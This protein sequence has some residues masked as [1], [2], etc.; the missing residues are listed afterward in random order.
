MK[1]L[2]VFDH[3]YTA[4]ACNNEPHK[5]S[6][7]AAICKRLTGLM[8]ERGE[9]V[10]VIDL[11]ADHFNPVMS[12]EELALWRRGIALN[13]QVADY[14]K[15]IQQADRI[16]FIFPIWWELMPAMTKGF[17]DK[18]YAKD[19]LYSQPKQ[20]PMKTKLNPHKKIMVFTVMGTPKLLYKLVF[21]KPVIKALHRGT[22]MKTGLKHFEWK[23]FSHVD[24]LTL[25]EREKLL[26]NISL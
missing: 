20:G 16:I 15:R 3:P 21:G 8:L 24:T 11:H 17:L 2:I 19:I 22:F 7:C 25:E 18:V 9:E 14:Q 26:Q 4:R 13:D 10:D 6:F 12:A 1:N 5:R 23:N